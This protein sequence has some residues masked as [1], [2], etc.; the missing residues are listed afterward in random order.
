M[1]GLFG[2]STDRRQSNGERGAEPP[3]MNTHFESMTLNPVRA[4][5]CKRTCEQGQQL[6]PFVLGFPLQL[7]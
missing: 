4:C 3:T 2:S 5:A 6:R 7:T 1:G